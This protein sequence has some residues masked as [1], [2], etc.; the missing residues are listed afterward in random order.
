[1]ASILKEVQRRPD[2]GISALHT[3]PVKRLDDVKAARELDLTLTD[4]Q[5]AIPLDGLSK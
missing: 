3:L 1:M 4:Y 5:I 2:V